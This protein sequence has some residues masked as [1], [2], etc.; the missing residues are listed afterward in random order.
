MAKSIDPNKDIKLSSSIVPLRAGGGNPPLFCVHAGNFADMAAVL[1]TERA[2]YGVGYQLWD[3]AKSN[4]TIEKLA[5]SH[6][7]KILTIQP[8]GPYYLIGY[9]IGALVAYEMAN[10]LVG[11]GESINLLAL[12]DIY[13]PAL[14]RD[15]S[16]EAM[17]FRNRYRVDRIRKYGRNLMRAQFSELASDGSKLLGRKA[18]ALVR[19][20]V[21]NVAVTPEVLVRA[22]LPPAFEGRIVLFRVEVPMDGGSE[23]SQDPSLGWKAY[24]KGGVDVKTVAG[25]HTTVVQLPHVTDLASKLAPLLQ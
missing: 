5:A 16:S 12:V 2:V 1:E 11:R 6:V 21:S 7:S 22:Y 3:E 24:V 10:A 14:Y 9:S 17:Q 19:S 4:L 23:F 25:N 15:R 20:L 13:N 8:K 18:T